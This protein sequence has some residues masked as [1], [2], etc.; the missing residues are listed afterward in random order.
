[1]LED[2][3]E[4][5]AATKQRQV[6]ASQLIACPMTSSH[7]ERAMEGKNT[8]KEWIMDPFPQYTGK[9][10]FNNKAGFSQLVFPKGEAQ[11]HFL[12]S[13]IIKLAS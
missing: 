1:M 6:G 8:W 12:W 4:M 11:R 13:T 9:Q 3:L 10:V 2:G 7:Q 5:E